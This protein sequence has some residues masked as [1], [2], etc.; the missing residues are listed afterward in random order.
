MPKPPVRPYRW[1]AEFYDSLFT[2]HQPWFAAARK[3]ILGPILPS[4]NSA[5]DLACGTG[6]TALELARSGL[7]MSAVDLSPAMCRIA[8]AKAR[9]KGLA[10]RVIHAD[11][12]DFRLPSPVDLVLCEFD[13]LNHIP[14]AADLGRVLT[15]VARALNPGGYFYFDV[16]TRLA[17]ETLWTDT[18]FLE[19]EKLVT[20]FRGAY[21]PRT[22]KASSEID[23]FVREGP[24]W[25]RH[26][27]RVEQVCWSDREMRSTLRKA[28]F[29]VT[30]AWDATAFF[31]NSP[32]TVSGCRT[33]YLARKKD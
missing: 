20:V 21:D 33:F 11:M 18:W 16:N 3:R 12:R 22:G 14:R 30:G 8:R 10:L 27:E 32:E 19:N 28:G 31:T 5:C 2:F 9:D 13:A 17:F 15:S 4:L 24:L 7:K 25:R 1:L 26:H 23:W 6:T 29:R